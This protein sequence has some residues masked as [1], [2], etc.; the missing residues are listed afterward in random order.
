MKA[1]GEPLWAELGMCVCTHQQH[2][3]WV[4]LSCSPPPCLTMDCPPPWESSH[5]SQ[6][7]SLHRS[8]KRLGCCESVSCLGLVL[9]TQLNDGGTTEVSHL[10][11]TL[12]FPAVQW[13]LAMAETIPPQA[14]L[15]YAYIDLKGQMQMTRSSPSRILPRCCP[16]L[17]LFPE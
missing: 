15:N 17:G 4:P 8:R 14:S 13:S 11:P 9:L 7:P 3:G 6:Q 10:S 1:D 5:E 2:K 12:P 16:A